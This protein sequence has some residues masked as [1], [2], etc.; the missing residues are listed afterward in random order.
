MTCGLRAQI[1]H[2]SPSSPR[3]LAILL[4]WLSPGRVLPLPMRHRRAR[5][6]PS[7]T[8]TK[9][10]VP[11]TIFI[12]A[13][14]TTGAYEAYEVDVTTIS[15]T[16]TSRTMAAVYIEKHLS[17]IVCRNLQNQSVM[18]LCFRHSTHS[19]LAFVIRRMESWWN[20]IHDL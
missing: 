6:G 14:V 5:T 8:S 16:L 15:D 10:S 9:S 12:Q 1:P 13:Y 17:R 4:Q 11:S 2:Y 18:I 19:H 20:R 3:T 7:M